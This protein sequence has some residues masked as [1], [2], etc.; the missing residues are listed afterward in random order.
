MLQSQIE[1]PLSDGEASTESSRFHASDRFLFFLMVSGCHL[2]LKE[3]P[4]AHSSKPMRSP[5][6]RYKEH[7]NKKLFPIEPDD[8]VLHMLSNLKKN[9]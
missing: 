2:A 8:P 5:A 4:T 7:V 6:V 9:S 1:Q 3:D